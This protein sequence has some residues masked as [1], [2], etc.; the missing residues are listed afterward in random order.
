V[1]NI[2]Q[3]KTKMQGGGRVSLDLLH[4]LRDWLVNHILV[5]DKR[6]AAHFQAQKGEKSLLGRFFARFQSPKRA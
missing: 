4:F 3:E 5:E 2:M 1:Q 6:Y